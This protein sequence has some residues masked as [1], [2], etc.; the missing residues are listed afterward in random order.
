MDKQS[1]EPY[2]F[3]PMRLR[4]YPLGG[5]YFYSPEGHP[6]INLHFFRDGKGDYCV[7]NSGQE[8]ADVTRVRGISTETSMIPSDNSLPLKPKDCIHVGRFFLVFRKPSLI[9]RMLSKCSLF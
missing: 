5:D 3:D 8:T 9:R 6:E 7:S 2:L 4:E 1:S